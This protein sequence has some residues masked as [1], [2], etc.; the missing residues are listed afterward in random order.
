MIDIL[1]NM[2]KY[3][4]KC[5]IITNSDGDLHCRTTLLSE[6]K[7]LINKKKYKEAENLVSLTAAY[8]YGELAP[9]PV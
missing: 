3:C 2:Q 1:K 5:G 7:S 9:K 6:V 4:T 8:W